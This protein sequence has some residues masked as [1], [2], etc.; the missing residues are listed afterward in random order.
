MS[1]TDFDSFNDPALRSAVRRAWGD[2]RA[3]VELRDKLLEMFPSQK[4]SVRNAPVREPLILRLRSTF[5]GLAAA[6]VFLLAV[7]LAFQ[8]WISG[9]RH[10]RIAPRVLAL[11]SQ[12]ADDLVAQHEVMT[13]KPGPAGGTV[14]AAD[15]RFKLR[16]RLGFPVLAM[17][18]PGT[19]WKFRGFTEPL[20]TGAKSGQL[21]FGADGKKFVSVFSMPKSI[22]NGSA[23]ACEYAQ[24]NGSHPLAGFASNQAVYCLVASSKDGS[25]SL[26]DIRA[27]R[28]T[29]RPL[30]G[31]D[32]PLAVVMV[33]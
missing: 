15:A 33:P 14:E 25:L 32:V 7:G 23:P 22:V 17:D 19:N 4:R 2:E 26:D 30:N 16:S 6:A 3:P 21:L 1:D 29:L 28:D 11:P 27:I 5:Y 24:V 12:V 20:I 13:K 31:V 9:Q 10:L 18:L 8:D